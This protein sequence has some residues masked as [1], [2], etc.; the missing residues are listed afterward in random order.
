M[1]C[2]I[3]NLP[4]I[5]KAGNLKS[6]FNNI[7]NFFTQRQL[8]DTAISSGLTSESISRL[9][10]YNNL[11]IQGTTRTQAFKQTMTGATDA[12]KQMAV[13]IAN[14]SVQLNELTTASKAAQLGMS[15]LNSAL[16]IGISLAVSAAVKWGYELAHSFDNAVEKA[17]KLLSKAKET[18]DENKQIQELI[19]KYKELK[20][21]ETFENRT[22]TRNQLLEL[23]REITDLV[24][25]EANNIDLV[26]GKLETQLSLLND[27]NNAQYNDVIKSAESAYEAAQGATQKFK[28]KNASFFDNGDI[29]RIR[30]GGI[31]DAQNDVAGQRIISQ[32]LAE[33][34]AGYIYDGDENHRE[35]I[36]NFDKDLTPRQQLEFLNRAID[37]LK[38][39]SEFDTR[40]RDGIYDQLFE[41][42]ND[43][44][45]VIKKEDR[46]A[47][48]YSQK[49]IQFNSNRQIDGVKTVSD[50]VRARQKIID[51]V[52][53]DE[54]IK[55]AILSGALSQTDINNYMDDYLSSLNGISEIFDKWKQQQET[56][57][58]YEKAKAD[59]ES[60][61]IQDTI[62]DIYKSAYDGAEKE[63]DN[64]R[65]LMLFNAN[66]FEDAAKDVSQTMSDLENAVK[67][68]DDGGLP[69][70]K[71]FTEF[72]HLAEYADDAKALRQ[73][74]LELMGEVPNDLINE[75]TILNDKIELSSESIKNAL[76]EL[77]VG[78]TVDL[79][80]RPVIDTQLLR[81]A[82]WDEAI[83]DIAT[84][85]SSTYTNGETGKKAIAINFTP[86][87]VDEN[88]NYVGVLSP[89]ELDEYAEGVIAGTKTD[90][91][92]LQIG[93]EFNGKN[94]EKEA[95]AF[96]EYIHE[97]HEYYYSYTN[98]ELI[99]AENEQ[100]AQIQGFI[101][102]LN[103]LTDKVK[104]LNGE[105]INITAK[106]YIKYEEDNI[107]NIIDKLEKEKDAQNEILESLKSQKEELEDIVS[108]YEKTAD[109]VGKYID[110]TQIKPLEN[111]KSEIEEYYNAE[112]EKL[113][114]ENE[115]RNR[116]IE[117][118]EKQDALANARKSKQRV[119]TETQ[120]Y[121]WKNNEDAINK[122]EQDLA[123]YKNSISIE[124]LEKARDKEVKNLDEQIKSWEKY[125]EEWKEQVEAITAADEELIA[126]K[127]LGADWQQQI[128]EQ[129][130]DVMVNYG[131]EYASYNNKLKNQVEVEIRATE[132]AIK[133]REKEITD[134]KEYKT[135]ISNLNK[136]ITDSNAQ[137]LENLNQFVLDE[138]S[139]WEDRINH[140]KRNA[141]IIRKLN[142]QSNQDTSNE[143]DE[144]FERYAVY[145][146]GTKRGVFNSADEAEAK[147]Q[148]IAENIARSRTSSN[149]PASAL[150]SMIQGIM[151][152]LTI[153]RYATGGVS[154]KTGFAWL[155]GNKN[156]SE[157]IFNAQQARELYDLVRSGN[158]S[159]TIKNNILKGFNNNLNQIKTAT[160]PTNISNAISISFDGANINAESYESFKDY[161]DRYTNDLF[162]KIQ[163]GR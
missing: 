132:Q 85:Y 115:E 160:A 73:A 89:D 21:S 2:S 95:N 119:Y 39:S 127:V 94:A 120:G 83:G 141:E 92:H 112:I 6:G 137:Y 7:T 14:G 128:S 57:S 153:E 91:L 9:T 15:L 161:M 52:S 129:N 125:K 25:Q 61:Q 145:Y 114:E 146:N 154:T 17:D 19:D 53:N 1:A 42:R 135:D 134:W 150:E 64:E 30:H 144:S 159:N 121:V 68:I 76:D 62:V 155:D 65:P 56:Y 75:L 55:S 90:D 10:Q 117:L 126:S 41:A 66:E 96:A 60:K 158:F 101:T 139:T 4:E 72:P 80:N 23:Q 79:A 38:S 63:L 142:E 108:D 29:L 116:N 110:R 123:D 100:K 163:T 111:Q 32:M 107:Q 131:A 54:T 58:D 105:L 130:I 31:E 157:V 24:G 67:A 118:Q 8:T 147:K 34:N 77:S 124:N 162:M 51:E 43:L 82:G 109:V 106:D 37:E 84:V 44:N 28:Y 143:T 35:F 140:M 33:Q 133:E 104:T 152:A 99:E 48:D 138:N 97:L 122:A 156:N 87:V 12:T 93:A 5:L 13:N 59:Y 81:D 98:D 40:I 36:I 88:G 74:I 151:R 18:E 78:G 46:A 45:E 113:K 20:E 103:K 3:L 22:E 50:F 26:N 86:I 16:N 11:I 148:S 27:I 136:E 102:L 49:I 149:V 47:L 70:P 71:L 69:E